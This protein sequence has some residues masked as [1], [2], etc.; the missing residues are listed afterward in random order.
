[1]EAAELERAVRVIYER[2]N[3]T[4]YNGRLPK[5]GTFPFVATKT[6]RTHGST[7][8]SMSESVYIFDRLEIS[9]LLTPEH[10]ESVVLHEIAHVANIVLNNMVGHGSSWQHE[11]RRLGQPPNRTASREMMVGFTVIVKCSKC[12]WWQGRFRVTKKVRQ[13]NDYP[14]SYGCPECGAVGSLTVEFQMQKTEHRLNDR[15]DWNV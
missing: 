15:W 10:I 2:T 4:F 6:L 12:A 13:V 8:Y 9:R 14:K 7:V 11:M 3:D 1:M 5:W